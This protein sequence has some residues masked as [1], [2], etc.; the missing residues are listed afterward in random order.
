[1]YRINKHDRDNVMTY[2]DSMMVA[3]GMVNGD[4]N[5]HYHYDDDRD[6]VHDLGHDHDHDLDLLIVGFVVCIVSLLHDD[7]KSIDRS[8]GKIH[9][10]DNIGKEVTFRRDNKKKRSLVLQS[11]EMQ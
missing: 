7:H 5:D 10:E 9:D 2:V 6:R 8:T 3:V 4:A 1:M 11:R